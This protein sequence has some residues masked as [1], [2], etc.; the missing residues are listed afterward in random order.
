MLSNSL[1][2][3]SLQHQPFQL[4]EYLSLFFVT[5]IFLLIFHIFT[6]RS[7]CNSFKLKQTTSNFQHL[8]F[9]VH[10]LSSLSNPALVRFQLFVIWVDGR[11]CMLDSKEYGS[12]VGQEKNPPLHADKL[13][14][15]RYKLPNLTFS[16]IMMWYELRH[17][18]LSYFIIFV[19]YFG[20]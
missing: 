20:I 17:C 11:C 1:C 9:A 6:Y 5:C 16:A 4:S 18:F 8:K 3:L 15:R 2:H 19:P 12:I 13:V 10:Q 14:K 7:R